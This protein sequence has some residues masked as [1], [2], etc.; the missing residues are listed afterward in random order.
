MLSFDMP[1]ASVV[2]TE[3]PTLIS[4]EAKAPIDGDPEATTGDG[5]AILTLIGAGL[6]SAGLVASNEVG[7]TI[8]VTVAVAEDIAAMAGSLC[9]DIVP[10]FSACS[11][12]N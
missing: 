5:L 3:A 8:E 6:T 10:G 7:G 2:P 11:R 9:P 4:A 1:V 12:A